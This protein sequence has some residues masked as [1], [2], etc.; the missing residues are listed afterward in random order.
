VPV[1]LFRPDAPAG[2]RPEVVYI[3]ADRAL[4][5][6]GGP[7]EARVKAGEAVALIEPRGMGETAPGVPDAR[8]PQF[9]GTDEKEAFLA[10]H[11][12]RPLLGQRVYDVLQTLRALQP[13]EGPI[14]FRL[15]GVGAGGPIALHA[16][17]L[18]DRIAEVEIEGSLVS[19]SAVARGTISR[20]GLAGVVPGVLESYDLPD[21]A[22]LIAPRPLTIRAALDPA[23]TP[24]PQAVLDAA[25]AP[26]TAAYRDR[27]AADRLVL[28]AGP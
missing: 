24:V 26:A 7:I 11:L 13:P 8:R 5:A 19:W 27:H 12:A 28:R 25:Y 23:G 21:L 15:I 4:A 16:A 20:D 14:A 3:G 2:G 9:F 22:A 6:P 17:A 1:L 18:D 10:L